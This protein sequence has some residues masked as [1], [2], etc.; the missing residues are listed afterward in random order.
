MKK[1]HIVIDTVYTEEE[2]NEAFVGTLQECHD[3]VEEQ[4]CFGY[5]VKP[6]TKEEL[7]IHNSE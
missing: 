5:E 6:M 2:G 7:K 3:W 4:K 1:T